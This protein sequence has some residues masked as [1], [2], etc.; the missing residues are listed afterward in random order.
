[1]F[2][3]GYELRSVRLPNSGTA[4]VDFTLKGSGDVPVR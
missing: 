3:N 4:R 2:V 1:V